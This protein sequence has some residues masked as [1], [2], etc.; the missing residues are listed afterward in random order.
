MNAEAYEFSFISADQDYIWAIDA[1][2]QQVYYHDVNF[3]ESWHVLLIDL[4]HIS[5]SS[6]K[7]IY[8]IEKKK[9]KIL[10][11]EKPCTG[12]FVTPTE[13]SDTPSPGH[14]ISFPNVDFCQ[15]EADRS[16]MFL[17]STDGAFYVRRLYSRP[18]LSFWED[19]LDHDLEFQIISPILVN[20]QNNSVSLEII[21]MTIST[22]GDVV[23]LLTGNNVL[24][25]CVKPCYDGDYL[26]SL[27][28]CDNDNDGVQSISSSEN[29]LFVL[30]KNNVMYR[31]AVKTATK[32]LNQISDLAAR[33][34]IEV[35][36]INERN[37]ASNTII[38]KNTV[39]DLNKTR[40]ELIK[41]ANKYTYAEEWFMMTHEF[42]DNLAVDS[43]LNETIEYFA[44]GKNTMPSSKLTEFYTVASRAH[45]CDLFHYRVRL[46]HYFSTKFEIDIFYKT[47]CENI[48]DDCK[49]NPDTLICERII[50]DKYSRLE[51]LY[52]SFHD[53]K[54]FS[55][56]VF[57]PI[58]GKVS[59]QPGFSISPISDSVN[60]YIEVYEDAECLDY[61]IRT[62]YSSKRPPC[63]DNK[64]S[65][66]G[67]H[68]CYDYELQ[69]HEFNSDDEGS[70]ADFTIDHVRNNLT[71]N[72]RHNCL[73]IGYLSTNYIVQ[74]G[75]KHRYSEF[76]GTFLEVHKRNDNRT[77]ARSRLPLDSPFVKG[78]RTT[79]ISLIFE[80]LPH[81]VNDFNINFSH[82][83]LNNKIPIVCYGDYQI[84]WVVY[85]PIN[86]R[87]I[88]E[89]KKDFS[90]SSPNCLWSSAQNK[91]LEYGINIKPST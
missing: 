43:F 4:V 9:M 50:E 53:D 2:K 52:I 11:C 7:Y 10:S 3:I 82:F 12:D 29:E 65:V 37:L 40:N 35:S 60:N 58:I 19:N 66:T 56:D 54:C 41:L 33:V 84:W 90:V 32:L 1:E 46:L 81:S 86:K 45:H 22:H 70:V 13:S 34:D 64:L 44:A 63:W 85:V 25:E 62:Y 5:V 89:Y 38:T 71:H 79:S 68:I 59:L 77:I 67:R 87:R 42:V 18:R 49:W 55:L 28:P 80:E 36:I 76:C 72:V 14:D 20:E 74:C 21:S 73:N 83:K 24:L 8:G 17:I 51:D 16:H 26:P 23:T 78:F 39:A 6:P 91:Y 61:R 57:D 48:S 30:C 15:V 88:V 69:N 31:R 47:F 27:G 75:K